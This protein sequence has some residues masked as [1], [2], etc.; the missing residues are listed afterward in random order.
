ML[1]MKRKVIETI[2]G[3]LNKGQGR[4]VLIPAGEIIESTSTIIGGQI[5][6]HWNVVTE[7]EYVMVDQ[8]E[9]ESRSVPI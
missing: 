8:D 4:C 5:P 2:Q 7:G 6:V 9:L 1:V 3:W